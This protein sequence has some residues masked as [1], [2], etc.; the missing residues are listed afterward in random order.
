MNTKYQKICNSTALTLGTKGEAQR[1]PKQGIKMFIASQHTENLPDESRLMEAICSRE[2]L[3]KAL[4]CVCRNKGAPGIDG[5]TTEELVPYLKKSWPIIKQ[6]LLEGK[7]QLQPVKQVEIP[8]VGSKDTRKLG[9]PT[10]LD[11]FISQAILQVLQVKI[12]YTF[13]EYSYGFRPGK[14][15][16]K[17][18]SKAQEYVSQGYRIVVDIDLEKFFNKVN[19]DKLMSEIAK[20]ITDKRL[21]KLFRQ[22]LTIGILENRLIYKNRNF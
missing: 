5:M 3:R 15:A 13:S 7:Y 21:L 16:H 6:Q 12:D 20:R 2:N 11:R 4:K 9:I 22:F 18:I 19:H 14:S 10:V 1:T 8:K 17:A